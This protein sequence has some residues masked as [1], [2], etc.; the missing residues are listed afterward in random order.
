VQAPALDLLYSVLVG[1][2]PD[3]T[4]LL[5]VRELGFDD[6]VDLLGEVGLAR[7]GGFFDDVRDLLAT[8]HDH[9]TAGSRAVPVR[10][11]AVVLEELDLELEDPPHVLGC[12][13]CGDGVRQ[14]LHDPLERVFG[15]EQRG[16]RSAGE[17]AGLAGDDPRGDP[18]DQPD[19]E[20]PGDVLDDET[21]VRRRSRRAQTR[22]FRRAWRAT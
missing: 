16:W 1:G 19:N 3:R 9:R 18:D 22:R 4:D 17:T 8:T 5:E 2:W 12:Q 11:H 13:R 14:M 21:A 15:I 20:E 7:A 10:R 6:R